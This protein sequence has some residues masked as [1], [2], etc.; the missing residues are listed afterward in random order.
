VTY[1]R[2]APLA[3]PGLERRQRAL[4]LLRDVRPM[5]AAR[6]GSVLP[7][8]RADAFMARVDRRFHDAY[9]A[10]DQ[11]YGADHD[12]PELLD[13]LL[14]RVLMAA[15]ERPDDLHRLDHRREIRPDWFLR[16]PMIGYVTYTDRFAGTLRGVGE[17]LDHLSDLGVT[18]LHLLPL[19][20]SR[21]PPNDG[22]YAVADYRRVEP[23]L[24]T[25]DD[26]EVLARDLHERDIA[27]CVDL[28]VNHTAR[29]HD[30]A[31]RAMAGDPI[32]RDYYRLFADR[33]LPDRYE[34]TL[35]EV[36][37]QLG[38]GNF[39]WVEE[40]DAWVWSSFHEFQWDL[41]YDN[42]RVFAEMLD[43]ILWLANRGVDV[44]R[45]DAIPFLA[46][47][48]GTLSQNLPETHAIVQAWRA[49]IGIAAPATVFKAEAIVAPGD[50]VGY[51]GRHDRIRPECDL[52]YNNQLMVLSWSALAQR[53][54]GLMT[55]ALER[56]GTPPATTTWVTYVRSHDDIGWAVT[57]EDAAD[58]GLSGRDHRAFLVDFFRGTFPLS[59]ARG[60]VFGLDRR[61]GDART[62]GTAASLTGIEQALE[63]D[64]PALLDQA[65]RRFELLYAIA[66]SYGGIPLIWMGD[67]L[68][69]LNDRSY[70]RDPQRSSDSRWL[71]R[72]EM[73]WDRARQRHDAATVPGRAFA[74]LA[75]LARTRASLPALRGGGDTTPLR[76][77]SGAVFA[78][79]RAHPEHGRVLGLANFSDQPTSID[80]EI[81]DRAGL[82][83]EVFDALHLADSGVH[84]RRVHLERLQPRWLATA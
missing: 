31:Q 74:T 54:V 67:E 58:V 20:A 84:G 12:L 38:K 28:V 4:E 55:R 2:P 34:E 71:H 8:D 10:L 70:R 65:L 72:P 79:L 76:T 50:L 18:Y 24:G 62:C 83:G 59:F 39:V 61:T 43:V 17:H 27:L 52:A 14:R 41:N 45:L 78:Y 19:L 37:P 46:K 42:P 25:V 60:D 63:L 64:D 57:D 23:A 16:E 75:H 81:L 21:P 26:L 51:L 29:E 15:V 66:F 32:Y 69:M 40:L 80:G 44:I 35:W 3:L 56:M 22:G 11:V 5:V 33:T 13:D 36:F 6:A 77:S 82:H 48:L 7:A 47:R 49:L 53:D 1:R 68:A 73:D 9:S 30:W